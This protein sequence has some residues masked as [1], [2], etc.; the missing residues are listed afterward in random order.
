MENN[1]GKEEW[2]M[3]FMDLLGGVKE[4]TS[5]CM[6]HMYEVECEG[7]EDDID[8]HNRKY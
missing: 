5:G 3:Y 1:I 6:E 7:Q 8:Q 4:D 2:R